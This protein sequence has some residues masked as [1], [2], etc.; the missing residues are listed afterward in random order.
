MD[1]WTS[2]LDSW[3]YMVYREY[4]IERFIEDTDLYTIQQVREVL[5]GSNAEED[6]DNKHVS[7]V[8]Q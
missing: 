5:E 4:W 6:V 8:V 2:A 1:K 7:I 3:T